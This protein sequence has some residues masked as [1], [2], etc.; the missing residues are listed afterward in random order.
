MYI[1]VCVKSID[2]VNIFYIS[3]EIEIII[4]SLTTVLLLFYMIFTLFFDCAKGTIEEKVYQ[5]QISKQRISGT[6]MDQKTSDAT[7]TQQDL[8]VIYFCAA[9]SGLH[10]A[11][12]LSP[13][14]TLM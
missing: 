1:S 7:F 9:L 8:K 14:F 10:D 5:R 6:V 13:Y 12:F 11:L 3:P 2:D 4:D